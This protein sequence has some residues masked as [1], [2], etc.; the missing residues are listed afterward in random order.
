MIN[1]QNIQNTEKY[2]IFSNFLDEKLQIFGWSL[3]YMKKRSKNSIF[4]DTIGEFLSQNDITF[5]EVQDNT[6]TSEK[7]YK[8]SIGNEYAT[9]KHISFKYTVYGSTGMFDMLLKTIK[10]FLVFSDQTDEYEFN[11]KMKKY[12]VQY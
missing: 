6:Y 9:Y 5:E 3:N 1:I 8:V 12:I 10:V 2:L 11:F 4:Y 7:I